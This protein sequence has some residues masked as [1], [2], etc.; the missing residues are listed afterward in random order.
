M[1]ERLV[2][3]WLDKAIERTFQVPFC[4]MLVN[5]GYTIVHLSR[6]CGMEL[7]KDILAVSP[8][9]IPCAYQLKTARGGRI[10]L[11][12]WNRDISPQ[13]TNLVAGK[14]VH[15]SID[16]SV[17][18]Q[19]YLVTN[20]ILEE[21]VARAIDDINR[22]WQDQGQGHLK[23]RTIVKGELIEKAKNLGP[24]LW[25]AEP[26]DAKL[27]F[28]LFL[29]KGAGVFPKS[30]LSSLL[31]SALFNDIKTRP[32]KEACKRQMASTAL[33]CSLVTSSFSMKANYLAELEAWTICLSYMIGIIEKW[34]M[35]DETYKSEIELVYMILFNSLH[36]LVDEIRKRTH[37]VEGDALV[38]PLYYRVRITWLVALLSIYAFW[39]RF[40][41]REDEETE[42]F[43]REFVLNNLDKM[44]LYGE[45]AIPKFL[46]FYW[47][48]R[49]IDGSMR[50]D[51]IL[52]DM[53]NAICQANGSSNED[54]FLANPY[55]EAEEILP[56]LLGIASEPLDDYFKGNSYMLEALVHLF[57]RKNWKQA[58]KM[59]WPEITKISTTEFAPKRRWEYCKWR[60]TEGEI[61]TNYPKMTQDWSELKE[62]SIESSG[63]NVPNIYKKYPHLFLLFL[64]VFPHRANSQNI[65]WLDTAIR[66]Y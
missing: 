53:I 45:A 25:P 51:F 56:H 11:D 44:Q 19:S 60:N 40:D 6:H 50:P 18:H 3:N 15:P 65:R 39:T 35:S 48:Y 37:Y 38:D 10:S 30:K 26:L 36:N 4:H 31:E 55:Y 33:L 12:Q 23:L 13:I 64:C 7:G 27:V 47:F 61:K 54:T 41:R 16:S 63:G 28:E 62:L 2:E 57:V 17:H 42:L 9:G 59:L 58:M 43:L 5:E 24:G 52:R 8:E 34:R 1:L 32:S 66:A 22:Q 14:I 21:E 49:K 20:G 46:A 29:E